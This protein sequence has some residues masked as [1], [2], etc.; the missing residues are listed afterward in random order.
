MLLSSRLGKRRPL[1]RCRSGCLR[2][3]S[4]S[5]VVP[6]FQYPTINTAFCGGSELQNIDRQKYCKMLL[7]LK[8][9][10]QACKADNN[11]L[12]TFI[13]GYKRLLYE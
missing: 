13:I 6:E 4:V 2:K 3:I 5:K 8:A 10:P 1:A 12:Q 11:Q 7:L 9:L